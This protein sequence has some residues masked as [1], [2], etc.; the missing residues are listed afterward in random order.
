MVFRD[1]FDAARVPHLAAIG[2][3]W[4]QLAARD[5]YPEALRI[6]VDGLLARTVPAAGGRTG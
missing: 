5:V 1:A 4:A 3:R 2:G 6:P